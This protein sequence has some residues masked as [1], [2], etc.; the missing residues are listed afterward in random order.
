MNIPRIHLKAKLAMAV[1]TSALLPTTL[2]APMGDT[3]WPQNLSTWLLPMAA[4][5]AASMAALATWLLCREENKQFASSH[6]RAAI[7]CSGDMI[8]LVDRKKMQNI[9][10]NETACRLLGYQ[11]EELLAQTP[12]QLAVGISKEKMVQ[13]FNALF[14]STMGIQRAEVVFRKK[15]GGE[16]PVELSRRAILDQGRELI[17]TTARDISDQKAAQQIGRAHV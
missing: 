8:L 9:E 7:D 13:N 2:I 12:F 10:A 5:L 17:L 1:A 15:D 4:I 11:R 3:P 6:F 14:S 16:I